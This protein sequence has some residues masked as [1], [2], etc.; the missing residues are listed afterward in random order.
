[1]GGDLSGL[2]AAPSF[3]IEA[4][5]DPSSAHLDRVQMV[6]GWLHV[7]RTHER[8]YDVVGSGERERRADGGLPLLP[9]TVDPETGTYSNEHGDA[10]LSGVWTDPD[11]DPA[12]PAFYYVRVLEIPTPRHST[13]DALALGIPV[14]ETGQPVSIQERAYTSPIH[15]LP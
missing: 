15:Y 1:M 7:G 10:T 13:L 2:D 5:K 12:Q 6:K 3:W 9:D 11:F 4:A 8:V 14:E